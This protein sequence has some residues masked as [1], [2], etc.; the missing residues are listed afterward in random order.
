M[1][2]TDTYLG[3]IEEYA[4]HNYSP[5]PVVLSSGKGVWVTDVDG[6]R[7]LDMLSS[8]GALN[9]GHA[10]PRI[11]RIAAAQ[12]EKLTLTSRA[13]C[14]DT[15]AEFSQALAKLCRMQSVLAMNSGA[16]AVETAIKLSRKWG[17]D[18][19]RV[20]ENKAKVIVFTD[21]FHGRTTTICGFSTNPNTYSGFGPFTPGFEIAP[22]GD[23]EKLKSLI[24]KNTVAV[25]FEPI[26]GEAGII[27]PPAGFVSGI[28]EL[29]TKHNILMLA[30][31]IQTGLCRT[32]A[33]FACDHESVKPDVYIVAKS[34]GGGIT[35]ISAVVSSKSI[36]DVL[37]PGTHGS[38]FGGNPFACA[39][40]TEVINL[41]NQERPDLR[42]KELGE[43]FIN[44]LRKINSP[45][46]KDIRGRGL[47]IGLDIAKD[48]GKAKK[49][50]EKLML[51]GIL[52]K[53]TR[54]QT[55]RFTPPLIIEKTEIDWA[56]ERID[57][58]FKS[59]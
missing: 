44:N 20:E 34:L 48:F 51:E 53:D 36:M 14:T 56:L 13:F 10:N 55:I 39:I 7:Y 46:I 18:V 50:C 52:C 23:L 43:Y 35:P 9:F 24:D 15:L 41:I 45:A 40:A 32:G 19:K 12:L 58:V 29:C 1:S 57:K 47:F 59:V 3:T 28:R 22:Y 11:L 5:L 8:Y 2:K 25:M 42:S 31:E 30:D 54:D 4:A 21:N 17:Y 49:F 33:L 37:K 6:K 38:T 16:E 27:I 26:Q